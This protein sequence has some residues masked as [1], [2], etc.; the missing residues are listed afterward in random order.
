MAA[1]MSWQFGIYNNGSFTADTTAHWFMDPYWTEF[2]FNGDRPC[3]AVTNDK[4]SPCVLKSFQFSLINGSSN[5]QQFTSSSGTPYITH[6]SIA[7]ITANVGSVSS[8]EVQ[9]DSAN[10][11]FHHSDLAGQSYWGSRP[12]N[13]K[14]DKENPDAPEDGYPIFYTFIFNKGISIPANGTVYIL[15]KATWNTG[16]THLIQIYP[17]KGIVIPV[18]HAVTWKP[19]GGNWSGSTANIVQNVEDGKSATKP[20]DPTRTAYTF[21]GWSP[22]DTAYTNVT[23]DLTYVAQWKLAKGKVTFY[24]NYSNSDMEIVDGGEISD[25]DYITS[26]LGS[27][28]PANPDRPGAYKFKGWSTSRQGNIEADSLVLWDKNSGKAIDTFYAIWEK[29]Y[30]VYVREN[31]KW[32]KKLNVRK[33][34][35]ATKT[36][37]EL[38]PKQRVKGSWDD[39]L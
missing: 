8:N 23:S 25:V 36:W 6:A 32:V 15:F 39:K 3:I 31:G 33:Y 17:T 5:G 29:I 28:K 10:G 14:G 16:D 35:A 2:G 11:H 22:N 19:N 30:T 20:S 4:S 34:N 13:A 37:D 27:T 18:Y 12:T 21:T 38:P 24:R 7:K 9:V 26:T 1:E